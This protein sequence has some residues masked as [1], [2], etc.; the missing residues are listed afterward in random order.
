MSLLAVSVFLSES[1]LTSI[2][3]HF[4]LFFGFLKNNYTYLE[5]SF[6]VAWAVRWIKAQRLEDGSWPATWFINYLYETA[7][8]LGAFSVV[9]AEMSDDFIQKSLDYLLEK[10]R[11]DGGWGES[12]SS[13]SVGSYVTLGYSSPS[14]TA[15]ILFGLLQFLRGRDYQYLDQLRSPINKALSFILSTQK[16]NGLW[17]D[18]TYVGVVFPRVQYMRYPIFQEASIL[19]VLGMYYQDIDHF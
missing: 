5:T 11:E 6:Q 12:P 13:F 3:G 18:S 15:L 8:V 7:N 9:D 4:E 19:E 10:Q 16:E 2:D 1:I 17:E 14:Q